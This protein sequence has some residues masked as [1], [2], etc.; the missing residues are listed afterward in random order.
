MKTVAQFVNRPN[1][2]VNRV[3]SSWPLPYQLMGIEVEAENT[4]NAYLPSRVNGWEVKGDGSLRNGREF[5]LSAPMSGDALASAIEEFFTVAKLVRMPSA[6]THIHI[7]MLD[8]GMRFNNLQ[9]LVALL[10]SLEH[11]IYA[12][13]DEGRENCGFCHPLTNMGADVLGAILSLSEQDMGTSKEAALVKLLKSQSRYYGL[14]LSA[15]F[16]YGSAEFRYF[17][18]ACSS[19][20]LSSW[21]RLVQNFKIASTIFSTPEE[22]FNITHSRE[23]Y[24]NFVDNFLAE[25]ADIYKNNKAY[26]LTKR[27]ANELK[28]LTKCPQSNYTSKYNDVLYALT[29]TRFSKIAKLTPAAKA[30][31]NY[32]LSS[33]ALTAEQLIQ[34]ASVRESLTVIRDRMYRAVEDDNYETLASAAAELSRYVRS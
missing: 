26:I 16:K 17:P 20:E 15:L 13:G 19:K 33:E 29:S 24:F 22:V 28:V 25:W 12:L 14:N 8:E 2:V 6:S 34:N 9:A 4:S 27:L 31:I 30:H 10:Y 11:G 32:V 7:D 21:V 3:K 1:R 23:S 18:T 5:V